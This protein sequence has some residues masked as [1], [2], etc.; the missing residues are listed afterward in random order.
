MSGENELK[1]LRAAEIAPRPQ[2]EPAW[3][4]EGLWGAGAVGLIGGAPK[5]CL[6]RARNKQD[7]PARRVIPRHHA[8]APFRRRIP[9]SSAR[10]NQ[11]LSR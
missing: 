11:R 2:D 4:I 9:V 1:V 10:H 3:L 8:A 7:H 5:C 6:F